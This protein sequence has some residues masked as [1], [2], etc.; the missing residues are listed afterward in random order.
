M[1][2]PSQYWSRLTHILLKRKSG[3]LGVRELGLDEQLF[4]TGLEVVVVAVRSCYHPM[5]KDHASSLSSQ[6]STIIARY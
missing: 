6:F 1:F 5:S 2:R 4:G 3:R